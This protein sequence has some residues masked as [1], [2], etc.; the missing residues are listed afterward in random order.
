MR[1]QAVLFD[2][3]GVIQRRPRGWRDALGERLGFRGNPGAFLADVF[4]A[5][6]PALTG[7]SDF[8]QALSNLLARWHCRT[9]LD[10]ALHTWTMIEADPEITETIRA[11][12]RRGVR[13]YLASNQERYK[14]RYMSKV[15][16][17]RRLFDTEFYSCHMGLKKPSGAYFR[18]VVSAIALPP[19]QLLFV[20]DLS[21]NVEAAREVGLHA[22]TFPRETGREGLNRILGEYGLL[23]A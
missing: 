14:A 19:N 12:R 15:L 18:A 6:T 23:F 10:E 11:L 13:C 22:V 4:D 8:P 9:T 5:E 3:D 7:Q 21:V 2:A 16:G 1:I 20:D 17:Y